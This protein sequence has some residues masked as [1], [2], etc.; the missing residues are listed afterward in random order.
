MGN[1]TA[2]NKFT[3]TC[4]AEN[5]IDDLVGMTEVQWVGTDISSSSVTTL[6]LSY[7][8]LRTSDGGVVTCQWIFATLDLSFHN[9]SS[10]SLTINSEYSSLELCSV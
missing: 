10:F 1:S 3:L 9:Q 5:V 7:D 4:T 8:P 6:D 2:G